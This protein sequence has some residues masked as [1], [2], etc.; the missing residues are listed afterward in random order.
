MRECTGTL[1]PSEL[2][3]HQMAPFDERTST[4]DANGHAWVRVDTAQG[5]YWWNIDTRQTQWHP[6]WER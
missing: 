2:S 6:L 3:A 5:S 4:L 1:A